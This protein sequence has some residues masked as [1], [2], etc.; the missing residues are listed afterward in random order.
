[1][2]IGEEILKILHTSDWHLGAK[3]DRR[4][5]IGEQRE[6][7]NE[8]VS[9][10]DENKVDVVIVAGDIFDQAVPTSDA[11]EL[12]Y[13]T[14]EKL[15]ANNERVIIALAGNH[16]DPKRLSAN[17]H[18]AK[19]HN[20]VL[21]GDLNPVC[22]LNA[23]NKNKVTEVGEGYVIVESDTNKGKERLAVAILP[24]PMEYRLNYKVDGETYEEKVK[25]WA[26]V[27]CK[28]F[29]RD[30]FNILATHLMVAGGTFV[31]NDYVRTFKVG[32]VNIVSKSDFPKADY[33]ALGHIH[34]YQVIKDNMVYCSA[35]MKFSYSQKTCGAVIISTNKDKLEDFK[36]VPIKSAAKMEQVCVI[37]KE[38]IET[39]LSKFNENDIVELTLVQ[40]IA[41]TSKDIKEIKEKYPCVLQVKLQLTSLEQDDKVYISGRDKL[42]NRELFVDF[43]KNKKGIEPSKE[44]V[45]LFLNL[46]EDN[47]GETN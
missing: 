12:F 47:A 23:G 20:I 32:D 3:T 36:F 33:Y 5:R 44:I 34:D 18:F 16:D 14:L 42:S 27:A 31:E 41:L 40:D 38:N 28:G 30:T 46:M 9:L 13:D 45:E 29:K 2:L 24:Y 43:Y 25:A 39:A 1:M 4:N 17:R 6:V 35:P 26:R 22:E 15:S 19:K 37:G 7:M 10:A 11:E 21:V 8:L